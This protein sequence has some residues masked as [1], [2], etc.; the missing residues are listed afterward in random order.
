MELHHQA[1]IRPFCIRLF[2]DDALEFRYRAINRSHR[3]A[4]EVAAIFER[5]HA[6]L[7]LSDFHRALG[8]LGYDPQAVEAFVTGSESRL[9]A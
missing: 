5:G 4:R 3:E 9:A 2:L 7:S 8:A 6:G 1:L